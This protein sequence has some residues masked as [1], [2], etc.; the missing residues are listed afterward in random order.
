MYNQILFNRCR[1]AQFLGRLFV[2]CV[3]T[4]V[5]IRSL[6]FQTGFAG[7]YIIGIAS[8][9]T[10]AF[11][12]LMHSSFG[13]YNIYPGK[14][15]LNS[16][17]APGIFRQEILHHLV[18]GRM[19]IYSSIKFLERKIPVASLL[20]CNSGISIQTTS[21]IPILAFSPLKISIIS[22][23]LSDIP[24]ISIITSVISMAI[25]FKAIAASL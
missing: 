20:Q 4:G 22:I 3:E 8:S 16:R 10:I 21:D 5:S 9:C 15:L 25:K 6:A 2:D 24:D 17:S 12:L 7:Q 1:P 11:L 14:C 23:T 13:D 18:A 19:P